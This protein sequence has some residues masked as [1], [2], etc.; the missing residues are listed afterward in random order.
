MTEKAIFTYQTR[1]RIDEKDSQVLDEYA[2]LFGKVERSLFADFSAGQKPIELKNGYLKRFGIT[3]RQFNACR[4]QIM[5]K[6]DSYN[7]L[8]PGLIANITERIATLKHKIEKL[9]KKRE[10]EEIVHQKKRR[11]SKLEHRLKQLKKDQK[12]KKIHLCFGGKKLFRAQFN[13]EKNGYGSHEEWRKEWDKAR[14]SEFFVL[15]SKDETAGNQSCTATITEDGTLALRLRLPPVL[16]EKYGKYLDISGIHFQYGQNTILAS[17]YSCLER[18]QATQ[19]KANLGR[20]LSY[21]FKKDKKG[22]IAFVSTEYDKPRIISDDEYGAIGLDINANHLALVEI[23]RFGNPEEKR[24][25]PLNTYGKNKNQILAEIG[26][27]A[28]ETIKWAEKV[29]KPIV[30]EKLDFGKKKTTIKEENTRK[31]ARMLSSL[32]YSQIIKMIIAKAYRQGVVVHTVNPAFTTI[33]GQAKFAK[34]YGL[35]KHHAAALCIAR[36]KYGYS[37]Q[38]PKSCII[39]NGKEGQLTLPLPVRNRGRHVW[40]FWRT[41]GKK[42]RAAHA[43]HFQAKKN[44]SSDPLKADPS[45]NEFPEIVG[46]IRHANR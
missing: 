1:L 12:E 6:I 21:R 28:A 15:G 43:A 40:S 10:N 46:E 29:K 4:V 42:I 45:D 23:D 5:G 11:L 25:I 44:R 35:T 36:R 13:L 39:L 26:N 24:T 9:S 16:S 8:Q 3:A 32:A 20:A 33:I 14:N 38:P 22:W 7:Q 27:I 19:N 30:L 17:L 2:N 34:R 41:V 37:E 18:R 31:N